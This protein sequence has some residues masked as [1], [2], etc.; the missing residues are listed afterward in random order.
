MGG[1]AILVPI[2]WIKSF[3]NLSY[4]SAFANLSII[5]ALA[6]V[7]IYGV[8]SYRN[9]PELHKNLNYL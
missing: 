9:K 7:S 8:D 2:S 5:V 3:D 4:V 6:I 1:A